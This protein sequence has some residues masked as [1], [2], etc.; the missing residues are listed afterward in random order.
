[1]TGPVIEIAAALLID[2]DDRMVLVR[3][4][5]TACYMQPGGKI[6]PGET[7]TDALLRE[8]DEE[9][10]LTLA[11]DALTPLGRHAAAAAHEPGHVVRATLFLARSAAPL[12]PRAEIDGLVR[13]T[14]AEA[15]A[16]PLAPL[17]ADAILPLLTDLHAG[18][19]R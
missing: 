1:M 5:G 4:R 18:A 9:L 6:A 12:T 16:L 8:L 2:A 14:P 17:T 7:A 3:K 11:P 10:G 13:V 15:R 19:R